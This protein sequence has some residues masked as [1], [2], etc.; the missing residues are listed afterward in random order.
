MFSAHT[1][2]LTSTEVLN[3][4]ETLASIVITSPSLIECLK[5]T[6]STEAVTTMRLQCFCAAMAAAISIQCSK[7]PPI[8]LLSVLVSLGNTNSFIMVYDS[9]GDFPFMGQRYV[10]RRKV[11]GER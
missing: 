9:L 3:E 6:L 2:S 11:K 5:E 10:L 4:R 7:R 1:S 8:K